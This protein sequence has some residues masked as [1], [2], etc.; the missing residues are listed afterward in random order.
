MLALKVFYCKRFSL[1][2]ANKSDNKELKDCK[3]VRK[4]NIAKHVM[5]KY[6]SKR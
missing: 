4:R 2:I 6:R 5:K 1:K 3:F